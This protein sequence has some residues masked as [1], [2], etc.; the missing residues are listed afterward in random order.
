MRIPKSLIETICFDEQV[1]SSRFRLDCVKYEVENE[2]VIAS[3]GHSLI[4]RSVQIDDGDVSCLIP[5]YVFKLA[6]LMGLS[7]IRTTDEA[8]NIVQCSPLKIVATFPRV[9]PNEKFP[10][11]EQFPGLAPF[12]AIFDKATSPVLFFNAAVMIEALTAMQAPPSEY[13]STDKRQNHVGIFLQEEHGEMTSFMLAPLND[14]DGA[15]VKSIALVMP[16]KRNYLDK[17]IE[18]VSKR[19]CRS[20]TFVAHETVEVTDA[21]NEADARAAVQPAAIH[22]CDK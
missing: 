12:D 9:A 6:R 1:G 20:T 7:S 11:L 18:E 17:T 10:A 21:F 13:S 2:R 5:A 3:D 22:D 14:C 16:C 8:I 4:R 15:D 19:G